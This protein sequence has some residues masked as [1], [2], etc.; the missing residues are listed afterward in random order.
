VID[1]ATL[2]PLCTL[3]NDRSAKKAFAAAAGL[4]NGYSA[5]ADSP[6]RR[7]ANVDHATVEAIFSLRQARDC[8]GYGSPAEA[9]VCDCWTNSRALQVMDSVNGN[10]GVT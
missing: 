2:S 4:Q 9:H 10:F 6:N 8:N 5:T 3:R 1:S 7:T